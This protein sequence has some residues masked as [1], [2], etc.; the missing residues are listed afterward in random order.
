MC[1]FE[2]HRSTKSELRSS[3]TRRHLVF[4]LSSVDNPVDNPAL[5][6]RTPSLFLPA[7][8]LP[9]LGRKENTLAS[10]CWRV[11]VCGD[12]IWSCQVEAAERGRGDP[13]SQQIRTAVFVTRVW[14]NQRA[15]HWEHTICA[16]ARVLRHL[17]HLCSGGGG[18]LKVEERQ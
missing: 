17:K 5:W 12:E 15:H 1:L 18:G 8:R 13:V 9:L 10:L 11:D 14:M 7:E 2:H 6:L 3:H 16:A 4:L